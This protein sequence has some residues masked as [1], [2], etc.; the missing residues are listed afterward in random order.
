MGYFDSNFFRWRGWFFAA[1]A[2]LAMACGNNQE[3][4]IGEIR[5]LQEAGRLAETI[6]P[7]RELLEANPDD[8]ELNH[9]YGVALLATDQPG[10]AAWPLRK[11]AQAPERAIEDGLLLTRALLRGGTNAEEATAAAKRVVELAPHRIDAMRL[12]IE[13]HLAGMQNEEA[14][15]D[16]ERL[17]A[18]EPGD[19]EALISRLMALLNLN[20]VDEAEQALAAVRAAVEDLGDDNEWLPRLCGATATFTLEKG[21]AEAAEALWNDCLEK[22]PADEIVVNGGVEFF[23][24]RRDWQRVIEILRRAHEMVPA[25][26]PFTE[27]L[28]TWLGASGQAEEAERLLRTAT[29]SEGNAPQAWV[30]LANYHEQRDEVAKARDALEKG[31][32]LMVEPPTTLVASY[33]DLLIRAGDYDKAEQIIAAFEGES[34]IVYLLRGRLLLARGN[35]AEALASFEEGLRL[36]PGNSVARR[37]AAQAAEQL[38]DYDRALLEYVEAVRADHGNREAVF[39]LVRLLEAL[40]RSAE[41]GPILSRYHAARPQDPEGLVQIIRIAGR[42]GQREVANRA[43]GTLREFPGQRGVLVAEIAAIQADRIGYASGIE[44]I[45]GSN[46]DLTHPDNAP[47]LRALVEYLIGVGQVSEALSAADAAV[48]AHPQL[49]LFHELRAGALRAAREPAW[50][51]EAFERAL[52]LEPERAS[53]LGGLAALAAEDGDRDTAIALYDRADRADP[54]EP[55]YA[56]EAIQLV[57]SSGDDAQLE[58]RLEALLVR[59]GTHA[60]AANLLARRLGERDPERAFDL[61]RRAVRF[62]GGPDALD[63]FGRMQ[64]ERGDAE[65]A[66]RT[67]GRSLELRPDSPSTRYW[68]AM[69]LS[70]TGDEDGAREALRAALESDAFP[71]REDA[72]AELAHLNAD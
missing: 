68:L 5:S 2:A 28:A 30:A 34:V 62:R 54:Q 69:A 50:A 16:V 3:A 19:V 45:R 27:A 40:G 8:L 39:D 57:A 20:R 29:Q 32:S 49:P 59:H 15:L 1:V 48:A 6:E 72:R 35:P 58:R 26:L 42:T 60:G 70:A 17:L 36:W 10:L 33:V 64:L 51:R 18:L 47:A 11:A 24:G 71:E 31:L 9:L 37:L 14:L 43:I 46:L 44:V 55:A 41:A 22:F 13:A 63:T 7:L 38:G 67:L 25:H 23:D 56:W 53:A 4:R 52:A 21:D 12:L 66:A 61:A 65:R